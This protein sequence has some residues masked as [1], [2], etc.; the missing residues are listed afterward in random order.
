MMKIQYLLPQN[1]F[2]KNKIGVYSIGLHT[3]IYEKT[4]KE[5]RK[6]TYNEIIQSIGGQKWYYDTWNLVSDTEKWRNT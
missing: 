6:L 1:V 5:V 4:R 2:N 3:V